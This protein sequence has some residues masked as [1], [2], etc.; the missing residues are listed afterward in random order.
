MF[1][2]DLKRLLP[3]KMEGV[4]AL[5]TVGMWVKQAGT[6]R[7]GDS[8]VVECVVLA[9]ELYRQVVTPGVKFEIWDAGFFA[10]GIVIERH[11]EGWYEASAS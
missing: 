7:E 6:F 8:V 2:E 11:E 1:G 5:N 9:P 10:E 4:G 3:M